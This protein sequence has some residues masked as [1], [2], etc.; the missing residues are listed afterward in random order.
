[1]QRPVF[2]ASTVK[3]QTVYRIDYETTEQECEDA[4]K[5]MSLVSPSAESVAPP[6]PPAS[7]R[8]RHA[9]AETLPLSSHR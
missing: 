7:R 5:R 8:E 1:M 6:P 4:T 3:D 9:L 2:G